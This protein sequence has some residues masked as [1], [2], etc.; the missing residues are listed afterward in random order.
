MTINEIIQSYQK[1]CPYSSFIL[2][3][4]DLPNHELP[5]MCRVMI[6][7]NNREDTLMRMKGV[8]MQETF[9]RWVAKD[10]KVNLREEKKI[11]QRL[12]I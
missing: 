8:E 2:F 11:K 1:D 7:F 10:E 9:I 4:S 3:L 5:Q 12:L 6:P